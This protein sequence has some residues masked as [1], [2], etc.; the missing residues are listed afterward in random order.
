MDK[1]D[2]SALSRW[3]RSARQHTYAVGLSGAALILVAACSSKGMSAGGSSA[4]TPLAR[5]ARPGRPAGPARPGLANRLQW[6]GVV[7]ILNAETG[8]A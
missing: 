8:V 1:Y 4:D 6:T 5:A 3:Y 7:L 2:K